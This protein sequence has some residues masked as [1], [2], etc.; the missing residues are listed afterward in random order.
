LQ[1]ECCAEIRTDGVEAA[2]RDVED[3]QH[4]EDEGDARRDEKQPRR[5]HNAVNQDDRQDIHENGTL[6]LLRAGWNAANTLP[7]RSGCELHPFATQTPASTL[8]TRRSD[9]A[10]RPGKRR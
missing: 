5:E 6:A 4:A 8:P 3:A 1:D 10:L 9:D 2:V 7:M